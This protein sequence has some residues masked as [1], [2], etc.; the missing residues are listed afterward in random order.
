[1]SQPAVQPSLESS[2]SHVVPAAHAF[3]ASV[4][5][6]HLVL[7]VLAVLVAAAMTY[8]AALG[9]SGHWTAVLA[10]LLLGGA[11]FRA[12]AIL[13]TRM[14]LSDEP[15]TRNTAIVMLSLKI[16]VLALLMM[17]VFRWVKPDGLTLLLALSLAPF[18]LVIL[19]V[20]RGGKLQT[21]AHGSLS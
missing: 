2:P 5:R 21:S 12:L 8:S 7:G 16:G 17:A 14:L 11:N 19:A 13:T 9:S 3:V 4:E 15:S 20:R 10:G 6:L 1:M 18:C